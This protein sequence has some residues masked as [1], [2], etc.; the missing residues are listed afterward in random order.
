MFF[1]ITFISLLACFLAC[2]LI[3]AKTYSPSGDF[4]VGPSALEEFAP[5]PYQGQEPFPVWLAKHNG[6]PIKKEWCPAENERHYVV[7]RYRNFRL[8]FGPFNNFTEQETALNKLK[9]LIQDPRFQERIE[10]TRVHGVTFIPGHCLK[11]GK[12]QTDGTIVLSLPVDKLKNVNE[13]IA[14]FENKLNGLQNLP[15]ER[16][17]LTLSQLQGEIMKANNYIEELIKIAQLQDPHIAAKIDA[18]RTKY[19]ITGSENGSD[20][21]S[22]DGSKDGTSSKGGG[23]KGIF[24]IG[25]SFSSWFTTMLEFIAEYLGIKYI[26]EKALLLAYI[27]APDLFEEIGTFLV[28]LQHLITPKSLDSFLNALSDIYLRAKQIMGA[29]HQVHQLLS[30]PDFLELVEKIDLQSAL[31][32]LERYHL[33][34]QPGWLKEINAFLPLSLFSIDN[35]KNFQISSQKL[36]SFVVK[37]GKQ[38]LKR[39]LQEANIPFLR[40]LDI[41]GLFTAFENKDFKGWLKTESLR[42]YTEFVPAR[43]KQ[44]DKAIEVLLNGDF[45]KVVEEV[46]IQDLSRYA[47]IEEQYSRSIIQAIQDQ[48]PS[49][50][51]L[52]IVKS[53]SHRLKSFSEP[54]SL[55]VDG[56]FEESL[57]EGIKAGLKMTLPRQIPPQVVDALVEEGKPARALSAYAQVKGA[58][59]SEQDIIDIFSGNW[60][61]DGEEKAKSF[62]QKITG[63]PQ[64]SITSKEAFEF[65][66]NKLN[67]VAQEIGIVSAKGSLSPSDLTNP[68]PVLGLAKA[69]QNFDA[70]LS[71]LGSENH[72]DQF[73]VELDALA[74]EALQRM[75]LLDG[76]LSETDVLNR[77]G[78][79][80]GQALA[81]KSV[82]EFLKFINQRRFTEAWKV[83]ISSKLKDLPTEERERLAQFVSMDKKTADKNL[84]KL[85]TD[86][87]SGHKE[88]LDYAKWLER[89]GDFQKYLIWAQ[90]NLN[91]ELE[92]NI[93]KRIGSENQVVNQYLSGEYQL[94]FET[95]MEKALYEAGFTSQKAIKAFMSGKLEEAIEIQISQMTEIPY[96]DKVG[97]LKEKLKNRIYLFRTLL[98]YSKRP[99]PQ[100]RIDEYMILLS[101]EENK[102]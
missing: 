37:A 15:F 101:M 22:K 30:D 99:I 32:E 67:D 89:D 48:D 19:N 2:F 62:F 102:Q 8:W 61:R 98:E 23:R 9:L 47:H 92:H 52:E 96:A 58:D 94:A 13:L 100:E 17:Q 73:L 90:N 51:A 5:V 59:I 16:S 75:G 33:L 11:P 20:N 71:Q 45:E 83:I 26:S 28:R 4:L 68:Y 66:K 39:G 21:G 64:D 84:H 69:L 87:F 27:I 18:L 55:F 85:T 1:K 14:K 12:Y 63:I 79:G 42:A 50:V 40:N 95:L 72:T 91:N 3:L 38:G 77:L 70:E 54:F 46:L 56:N 31:N 88:L 34:K 35:L 44:Y 41:D 74:K 97:L 10:D 36:Q 80:R 78:I 49:K 76:N 6:H 43:L 60:T 25:S 29:L 93:Q 81:G 82:Q 57:K 7:Y 86:F 53:Q 65:I 24:N